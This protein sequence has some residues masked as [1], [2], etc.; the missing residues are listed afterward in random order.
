MKFHL[1]YVNRSE[2]EAEGNKRTLAEESASS[3]EVDNK[4]KRC[5]RQKRLDQQPE[6]TAA[7][8]HLNLENQCKDGVSLFFST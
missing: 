7:A 6:S 8:Y 1:K 2:Q 4:P 5:R 3:G